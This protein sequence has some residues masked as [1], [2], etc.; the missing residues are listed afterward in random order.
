MQSPAE[1]SP[2]RVVSFRSLAFLAIGGIG[3]SFPFIANHSPLRERFEKN[4]LCARITPV[5][6]EGRFNDGHTPAE[7]LFDLP[8]SRLTYFDQL[9]VL[10]PDQQLNRI[11]DTSGPLKYDAFVHAFT[12]AVVRDAR[13]VPPV[14]AFATIK[15]KS[16]EIPEKQRMEVFDVLTTNALAA[17]Q[18][19]LAAEILRLSCRTSASTWKTVKDMISASRMAGAQAPATEEF[20]QWMLKRARD[21]DAGQRAEAGALR[22][23]L[24]LEANLPAEALDQ[25]IDELK[26][27]PGITTIP[28]ELMERT[29]RAAVLAERTKEMLPWVESYLA[30]FPEAGLSWQEL[31]KAAP[32]DS[33]KQWVKRAADIADGNGLFEK[34]YAHHQ[35]LLAAGDVSGLDRFLPLSDQLGHGVQTTQVMLAIQQ[36]PGNEKIHIQSARVMAWSGS[37]DQAVEMFEEWVAAHPKDREAAFELACMKETV[38]EIPAAVAEFE[39]F[40][41]SF[42]A[43]PAGVKKLASLRI[44]NGQPQSALRE[45]DGLGETEF[46]AETLDAY[47]MLAESL[48]RPDSLQR[49]LRISGKDPAKATPALYI[50][51]TEIAQQKEDADAP[52]M[53]LREGI[54]HL[55]QSPSLRVKLAALLLEQEKYDEALSEALHPVVRT[56]FDALSLALAAGVHTI[57]CAEVLA[58]AGPDFENRHDLPA[59]TRLDLAAACCI[60]GD[61]K[62]GEALFASVRPD[63]STFARLAAARLLAGQAEQAENLARQNILQS[64]APKPSDWILLGDAQSRQGRNLEANDSYSKALSVVSRKISSRSSSDPVA[65]DAST[66]QPLNIQ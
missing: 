4:K 14:E 26:R 65:A 42:P 56:R 48:D 59:A 24:A 44:R 9:L 41:R 62:R 43:D 37:S 3:V 55:P 51:M 28:A 31:I 10:P 33:Y 15:P 57:R 35:R 1:N 45:L 47:A 18:P 46:D 60:T 11:F 19:G 27:E 53:V 8:I 22:Y 32:S 38:G 20:R 49:A 13:A 64:T 36:L 40:L 66:I 7:A 23:T 63:R 58:L 52:L 25:C 17:V 21:L 39:K 30:S 6:A 34:A 5:L 61:V 16:G 29:H 2:R 54:K 50:R 12:L